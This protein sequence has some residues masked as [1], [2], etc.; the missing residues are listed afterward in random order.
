MKAHWRSTVFLIASLLMKECI[1]IPAPAQLFIMPEMVDKATMLAGDMKAKP[2]NRVYTQCAK[3]GE[4]ALT[5]DELVIAKQ[6]FS[7]RG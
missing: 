5:F 7:A 1:A 6:D 4:L 3:A 2:V